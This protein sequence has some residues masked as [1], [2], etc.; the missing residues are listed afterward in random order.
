MLFLVQFSINS[1]VTNGS[2]A[3]FP[4]GKYFQS[5]ESGLTYATPYAMSSTSHNIS[6]NNAVI[7][8]SSKESRHGNGNTV[9][10]FSAAC[11][12]S[13]LVW[14]G[15]PITPMAEF[16]ESKVLQ[17]DEFEFGL[18]KTVQDD[19]DTPDI[20]KDSLTPLNTVNA[21]SPNKKRV[22]PP[23]GR[24]REYTSSSSADHR[25]ARKFILKAVPSFPP[26]TP[27]IDS[28]TL[29]VEQDSSPENCGANK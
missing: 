24:P 17:E 7:P 13:S 9:D 26:L 2:V 1:H 23:H 19:I 5:P 11:S 3:C 16:S 10:E 6:A 22:S 14:R 27:C 15:S 20:L 25:T 28:K 4:S 21:N 29:G 8:E 18:S 12:R